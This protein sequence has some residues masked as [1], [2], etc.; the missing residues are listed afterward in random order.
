MKRD[1]SALVAGLLFGIGLVV[2]GMTNPGKVQDFLDLFGAWDASLAFVMIG[3][4][5]VH[6][7]VV[8]RILRLPRPLHDPM[9]H[10]PTRTGVDAPLLLGAALFG[11]GWGLAGFCPG[12][13]LV[14]AAAATPAAL[15]F[16]PAM[17]AGMWLQQRSSAAG[18]AVR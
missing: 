17:L 4:I 7:L 1:L 12:P 8:R 16:V 15:V 3:A 2:S 9:F 11:V 6:A 5:A 18:R 13:A 10:L 14:S